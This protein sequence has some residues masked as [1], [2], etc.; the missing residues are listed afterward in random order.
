MLAQAKNITQ[1]EKMEWGFQNCLIASIY[2]KTAIKT[3]VKELTK[4]AI[5]SARL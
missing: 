4:A 5:I 3:K 1:S 2:R